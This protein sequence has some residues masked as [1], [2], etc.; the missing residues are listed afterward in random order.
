A[1]A[2]IKELIPALEAKY[3]LIPKASARI[4]RGHSSGGWSSVWLAM[5]YPGTFGACWA[6]APDPLDFR[7]F[8]KVDIYSQPNFYTDDKG[9][10]IPSTLQDGTVLMTIRQE[11]AWE[12]AKGPDNTSGEQW[13]SWFA[14][15]GPRNER[16]HPAALFDFATGAM[17]KN[18]AEQ[19]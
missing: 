2:L 7:R 15:F 1:D 16:G 19:Y 5:Q 14:V 13:D 9:T 18:I 4:I 12:E 11:N 8:Q 10:E 3:H 6:G 17:N